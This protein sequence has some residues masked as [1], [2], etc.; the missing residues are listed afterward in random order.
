MIVIPVDD[1]IVPAL[2][3]GGVWDLPETCCFS[4]GIPVGP[5]LAKPTKGVSEILDRFQKM[6]FTCE[7]KY[8]GEW[9]QIHYLEDGAVQIYSRNAERNTQKFPDVVAASRWLFA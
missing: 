5:M 3:S 4:P 9:A 7:H 2:L 6:E 8:D 1:K